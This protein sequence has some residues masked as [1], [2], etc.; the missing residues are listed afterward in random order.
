MRLQGAAR[1]GAAFVLVVAVGH[2]RAGEEVKV[3]TKDKVGSYLTDAKGM[4]LYTFK[5]DWPGKSACA[6]ACVTRWP[7]FHAEKV[8]AAGLEASDFATI[9]RG[10]GQKQTTYKGMPL[11]YFVG[12]NAPGD[13]NGHEVKEVWYLAKP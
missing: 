7:L 2:A 1:L 3:A 11:Y 13:T 5:K 4:S 9:T 8:A 12:D 10:D 6:G